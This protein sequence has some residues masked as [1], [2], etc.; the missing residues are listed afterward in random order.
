MGFRKAKNACCTAACPPPRSAPTGIYPIYSHCEGGRTAQLAPLTP[1]LAEPAVVFQCKGSP[2]ALLMPFHAI[3]PCT[4]P[5]KSAAIPRIPADAQPGLRTPDHLPHRYRVLAYTLQ[6]VSAQGFWRSSP[7][8][9]AG[10]STCPSITRHG[11][12]ATASALPQFANAYRNVHRRVFRRTDT[13]LARYL[14]R[15]SAWRRIYT[16]SRK[17]LHF[18]NPTIAIIPLRKAGRG[19]PSLESRA[20][21]R[22]NPCRGAPAPAVADSMQFDTESVKRCWENDIPIGNAT[23]KR[24][25]GALSRN[26]ARRREGLAAGSLLWIAVFIPL[27]PR[28]ACA[29]TPAHLTAAIPKAPKPVAFPAAA[30][31]ASR[32]RPSR[33]ATRRVKPRRVAG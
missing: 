22:C 23:R 28:I 17:P 5:A 20:P 32:D 16:P 8:P 19:A 13:A 1:A 2:T 14:H 3:A 11:C 10:G 25:Y 18:A 12:C 30:Q 4:Q 27:C 15:F 9:G 31:A 29:Q 33:F 6:N 24:R 26:A 21:P 7:I